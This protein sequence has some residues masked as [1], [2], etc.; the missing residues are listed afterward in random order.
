MRT[1]SCIAQASIEMVTLGTRGL[2]ALAGASILCLTSLA[3]PSMAQAQIAKEGE[4]AVTHTFIV[5]DKTMKMGDQMIIQRELT[6]VST[7]DQGSGMFHGLGMRCLSFID[8]VGGKA[9]AI[10]RC[11]E[12]DTDGDQIY[13]TFENK[14]GAGAHTLT[15]GTG[16]YSGISGRQS[17][18]GVRAVKGPDGVNGV[19]I[20]LKATWKLP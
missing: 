9:A 20:P 13:S 6:G 11:V 10:G 5:S 19:I 8:I 12:T 17:F 7:N 4:A 18:S 2:A 14:A 3:S 16:K 15:G 1:H